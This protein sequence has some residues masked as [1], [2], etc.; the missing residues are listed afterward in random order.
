MQTFDIGGTLELIDASAAKDV[1]IKDPT[2][3]AL[4]SRLQSVLRRGTLRSVKLRDKAVTAPKQW[5]RWH[6]HFNARLPN[7]IKVSCLL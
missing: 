4:A 3:E 2:A 6:G 7:L 1:I 5:L